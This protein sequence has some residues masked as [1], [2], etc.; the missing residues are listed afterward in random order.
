MGF[1]LSRMRRYARHGELSGQLSSRGS[2]ERVCWKMQCSHFL[3]S[4]F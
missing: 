3:L 4:S 1:D 2:V